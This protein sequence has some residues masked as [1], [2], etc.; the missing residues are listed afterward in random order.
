MQHF[1]CAEGQE[2]IH[3]CLGS[4]SL[5]DVLLITA[6]RT[7]FVRLCPRVRRIVE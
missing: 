4:S 7:A 6:A 3:R 1:T 5:G 2:L